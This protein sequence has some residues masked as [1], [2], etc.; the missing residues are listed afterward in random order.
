LELQTDSG[1]RLATRLAVG[2]DGAGS[3]LREAAGISVN[4]RDYG[5]IGLVVH[6]DAEQAHRGHALP[7]FTPQGVL[8]LLPMPDT[9]E[10][11]QVSMVWSMRRALATELQA[12]SPTEIRLRLQQMLEQATA[13]RLGKLVPRSPL[14]GFP[15]S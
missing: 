5:A 15:L 2:A 1:T 8:A 11:P 7:G 13:G 4:H 14:H 3:P 12:Q 9:A 6:L 10:G